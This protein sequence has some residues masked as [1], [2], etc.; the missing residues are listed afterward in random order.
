MLGFL[1]KTCLRHCGTEIQENIYIRII[2][3]FV[4]K[5]SDS[6]P[7][8]FHY[9]IKKSDNPGEVNHMFTN[10]SNKTLDIRVLQAP[11]KI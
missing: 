11:H 7:R 2:F 10:N 3:D 1:Y 9:R 4:L 8:G 5:L 6:I